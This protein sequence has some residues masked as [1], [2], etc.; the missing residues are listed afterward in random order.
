MASPPASKCASLWAATSGSG[1]GG[2]CCWGVTCCCGSTQEAPGAPGRATGRHRG[3][4]DVHV[5]SDQVKAVTNRMKQAVDHPSSV[6]DVVRT[7]WPVEMDKSVNLYV[8][9]GRCGGCFDAWGL[10]HQAADGVAKRVSNTRLAHAEVFH[11]GRFGID[12]Q[13]PLVQLKWLD[14]PGEPLRYR[15]KLCLADGSLTTEFE[16]HALSYRIGTWTNPDHRDLVFFELNWTR[17]DNAGVP[18]LRLSPVRHHCADYSGELTA[19]FAA[20]RWCGF[21]GLSLSMGTAEGLVL[22]RTEGDAHWEADE[23]GL[24]ARLASPAGRLGF[25]LAIGPMSRKS[26]L[27]DALAAVGDRAGEAGGEM[28]CATARDA[29]TA[30]WLRRWGNGSMHQLE[31]GGMNR[32]WWRSVYHLL[33]TYGPDV[34]CPA[35]PMGYTGN[36]WGFHFPQDLAYIHPVFLR[37]GHLDIARAI[38]EFYHSRLEQQRRFTHRIYGRPGVCWAWEFPIGVADDL[39][40]EGAPN[41]F[42]YEIH[43]AAYPARMA[44][45]TAQA[46]NEDEWSRQVA[47]PIVF[48]SATFLASALVK[49]NDGLW[50]VLLSPSMGQDEYGGKDA[51]DY[52][53]ALFSA[54]YALKACVEMSSRLGM[55]GEVEH[56]RHILRDGLAYPRLLTTH[57][58]YRTNA[59]D[60]FAAGRQKHPVQLNP[61]TLVPGVGQTEPMRKAWRMRHQI[62]AI[63]REGKHHPGVPGCFYDGWTLFSFLLAAGRLGDADGFQHELLQAVPGQLVDPDHITVYESS[64]YWCAYYTT[65]MGLYVQAQL[66]RADSGVRDVRAW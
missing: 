30:A 44:Y 50:G 46:L 25:T 14:R 19:T 20:G 16:N 61:L 55:A 41:D 4:K 21:D 62:C 9:N 57:G 5:D 35:P 37:L 8:G 13:V 47:W 36:G 59:R 26:S 66:S 40:V 56:F 32:L 38:V 10:Q 31:D 64:G 65:S 3:L 63:Q 11:H 43:N 6:G 58:F 53:C 18:V 1:W 45:E 12:T 23:D 15:Q 2:V 52:L 28:A 54:E 49:G 42:Q 33:A 22:L 60:A 51:P 39:L 29:A 24:A 17:P 34:R 48:A 27:I 7:H